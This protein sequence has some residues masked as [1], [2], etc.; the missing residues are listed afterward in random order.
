MQTR[1]AT[2][3]LLKWILFFASK[4]WIVKKR[5]LIGPETIA[6]TMNK[7][8]S[9]D[10]DDLYDWHVAETLLRNKISPTI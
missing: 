8:S 3:I 7:E 9:V 10:I 2:C 5:T 6:Y 1:F 4:D